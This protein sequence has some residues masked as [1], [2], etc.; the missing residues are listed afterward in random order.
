MGAW[1][2]ARDVGQIVAPFLAI[3]LSAYY[4]KRHQ[5]R[6]EIHRGIDDVEKL[7]REIQSAAELYWTVSKSKKT[8]AEKERARGILDKFE[9]LTDRLNILGKSLV[10]ED[11]DVEY[12]RFKEA[13]TGG[14]F[15]NDRIVLLTTNDGRI[16]KITDCG[17][18]IVTHLRVAFNDKYQ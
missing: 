4:S 3:S 14:D 16:V 18:A 12:G 11:V 15:E 10:S 6:D 17:R 2:V 8:R 5:K 13:C 9:T 1:E 7:V